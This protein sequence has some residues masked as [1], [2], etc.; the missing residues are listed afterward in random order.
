MP[1]VGYIQ[2]HDFTYI[3]T[4]TGRVFSLTGQYKNR[5]MKKHLHTGGYHTVG[6]CGRRHTTRYVHRLVAQAFIPN[7]DSLPEVNHKNGIK[8]DNR[9]ENLEWVTRAQNQKHCLDNWLGPGGAVRKEK[10]LIVADMVKFGSPRKEI[11]NVTGLNPQSV[12]LIS[13]RLIGRRPIHGR[14]AKAAWYRHGAEIKELAKSGVHLSEI[15]RRL[16]LHINSVRE[17]AIKDPTIKFAKGRKIDHRRCACHNTGVW[18]YKNPVKS[19]L[20]EDLENASVSQ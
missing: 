13:Q 16:G 14:Q 17:A 8:T 9:V 4:K 2:L 11:A 15:A 7:P 5:E 10:Q 19:R 18:S 1:H 20:P 6:L 3:V 12:S